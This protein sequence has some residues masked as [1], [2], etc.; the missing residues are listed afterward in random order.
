MVFIGLFI[1]L[2]IRDGIFTR[3]T[4]NI[5]WVLFHFNNGNNI[6]KSSIVGMARKHALYRV[7]NTEVFHLTFELRR[8]YCDCYLVPCR[9]ISK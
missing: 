8:A 1:R 3:I 4:V 6:Q 2:V 5:L 7:S 9:H